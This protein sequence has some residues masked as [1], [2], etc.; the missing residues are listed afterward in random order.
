MRTFRADDEHG[1]SYP[2]HFAF[3]SQETRL[4]LIIY[5][6]F[7]RSIHASFLLFSIPLYSRY[8]LSYARGRCPQQAGF[9]IKHMLAAALLFSYR[10]WP[11][12]KKI[13]KILLCTGVFFLS[14]PK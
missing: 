13:K 12:L 11:L 14:F 3:L 6:I 8:L 4:R 5:P 7:M 10:L 2:D 1:F 9:M